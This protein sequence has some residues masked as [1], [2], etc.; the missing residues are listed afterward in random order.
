MRSRRSIDRLLFNTKSLLSMLS[1]ALNSN[2]KT[3]NAP[4]VAPAEASSPAAT[5]QATMGAQSMP[6]PYEG[7]TRNDYLRALA[8]END[9][10]L[11]AVLLA[12]DILGPSEDFDGLVTTLEDWEQFGDMASYAESAA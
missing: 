7:R 10:P 4:A 8:E 3:K 5:Y 1:L 12:A 6:D 2:A 11:S 9:W